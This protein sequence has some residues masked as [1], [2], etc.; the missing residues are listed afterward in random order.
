MTLS[1][2]PALGIDLDFR[3]DTLSWLM[4]LLVGGV[5]ALVLVY[6]SA[7]FSPA[8]GNLGRFAAFLVGFAGAMLGLVTSDNLVQLYVFWEL[9]TVFSYLLIGHYTTRKSSRRAATKAILVTTAGG[10]VMLIGIVLI[11]DLSGTYSITDIV[12]APPTGPVAVT[13]VVLL[14]VGAASKSALVP[15]HFWLPAAMAAPTPVSAYLHAAAMVKAGI[16]LVAR[17]A[18]G[19]AGLEAWQLMILVLGGFSLVMGGYQALRQHD[20]KLLLAYGTVSQLGLLAILLGTG[21]RATALAGLALLGAHAMFKA[22]LFLVVGLVDAATGTRDLRNLSAIW[23]RLPV[24]ITV[25][26]RS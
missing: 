26:T 21:S 15:L 5:G 16:Y 9:T 24:T 2:I 6:C 19:Y 11:G 1:W 10:L 13:A 4:V 25:M 22:S 12:A 18:P 17:L 7:Y 3:L 8:S 14:L 20:L 23:R